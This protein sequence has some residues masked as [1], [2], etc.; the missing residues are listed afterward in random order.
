MNIAVGETFLDFLGIF[1]FFVIAGIKSL[2]DFLCAEFQAFEKRAFSCALRNGF[3]L[4]VCE[5][6]LLKPKNTEL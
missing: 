3:N 1:E 2:A 4:G 6:V 5:V